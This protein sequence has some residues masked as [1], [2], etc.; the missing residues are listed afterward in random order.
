MY[1]SEPQL[2][3]YVNRQT[4]IQDQFSKDAE[5]LSPIY[6]TCWTQSLAQA[7]WFRK[8]KFVYLN[9]QMQGLI[10]ST[11]WHLTPSVLNQNIFFC[12]NAKLKG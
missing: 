6:V 4:N 2:F 3:F 12:Y 11:K 10:L 8:L 5:W 7:I 9:R 1:F